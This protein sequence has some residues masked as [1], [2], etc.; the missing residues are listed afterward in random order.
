[1]RLVIRN[2]EIIPMFIGGGFL[3]PTWRCEFTSCVYIKTHG[4]SQR[5]CVNSRDKSLARM[6]N[7]DVWLC[8]DYGVLLCCDQYRA[9]EF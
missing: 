6:T 2:T 9:G 3:G 7:D 1:M 8:E 5:R 4:R